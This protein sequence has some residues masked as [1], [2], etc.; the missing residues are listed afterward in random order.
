MTEKDEEVDIV[1]IRLEFGVHDIPTRLP[2]T[3]GFVGLH[4]PAPFASPLVE[5]L[6]SWTI[7]S[8]ASWHSSRSNP[9]V[10]PRVEVAHLDRHGA[11]KL[12]P[13]LHLDQESVF[14]SD[15]EGRTLPSYSESTNTTKKFE[16]SDAIYGSETQSKSS[17]A[18]WEILNPSL[19]KATRRPSIFR[20]CVIDTA[21][22]P[23]IRGN[24]NRA[25]VSNIS[26]PDTLLRVQTI[27]ESMHDAKTKKLHGYWALALVLTITLLC[28]LFIPL[29][30]IY[31]NGTTKSVNNYFSRH[32]DPTSIH[33]FSKQYGG[34]KTTQKAGK[35]STAGSQRKTNS[36]VPFLRVFP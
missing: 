33:F 3:P 28:G 36:T 26:E 4:Q 6:S 20:E 23:E 34:S 19:N 18:S 9:L 1:E 21:Q 24:L 2:Q 10:L 14:M 7:E 31:A 12:T 15:S 30:I 17:I 8:P 27:G 11:S 35:N 29:L 22:A 25:C 16:R 32:A 13:P 5:E